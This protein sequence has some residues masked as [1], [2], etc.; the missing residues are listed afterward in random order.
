MRNIIITWSLVLLTLVAWGGFGFLTWQLH[1][2]RTSYVQAL[3]ETVSKSARDEAM[4]RLR[5]TLQASAYERAALEKI[6]GVS[7]LNAVE[8]IEEAGRSAGA[9]GVTIGEATPITGTAQKIGGVTIV[10][11]ATG[12][13]TALMRTVSLFETLPIPAT[14]EMFEVSKGES[15][16]RLTARIRVTLNNDKK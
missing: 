16:W 11:N 14:V 4:T 13:F 5:A 6:V 2:E 15:T 7:I 9:T 8:V 1:A 10:V 12:S 3:S